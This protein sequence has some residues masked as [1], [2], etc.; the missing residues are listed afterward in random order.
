MQIISPPVCG[1]ALSTPQ[2]L[3]QSVVCIHEI[4][5]AGIARVRMTVIRRREI[6]IELML[7]PLRARRIDFPIV[8][9]FALFGVAQEVVGGCEFLEFSSAELSPN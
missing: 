2:K 9:A 5:E 6:P 4:R 8:E 3:R 7:R 1:R